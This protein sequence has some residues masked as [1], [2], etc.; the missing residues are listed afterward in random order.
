METMLGADAYFL[1]EETPEMHMHTMKLAVIDP[2]TAATR[3]TF[4][5]FRALAMRQ[6][7]L[8]PSFRRRPLD[9][10]FS[11][12]PPVWLE[13]RDLDANYH[14]QH[15][16]LPAPGG[17]DELN[18]VMSEVGSVS[19][20]RDHP[21]WRFYFIE[22]LENGHIAYLLKIHHAVA[23]GSVS[24]A[25]MAQSFQTSPEGATAPPSAEEL[26]KLIRPDSVLA[27]DTFIRFVLSA[28][29]KVLRRSPSLLGRS[30][31]SI[32]IDLMRILQG[33]ERPIQ[34]FAGPPTRFNRPLSADRIFS[35]VTLSLEDLCTIKKAF[36]C[37]VNDVYLALV[38]GAL[39]RYLDGHREL[40][41][42]DLTAVVPVS[43]REKGDPSIFGNAV[44]QWFATTGSSIVDPAERL[45]AVSRSTRVSRSAFEAKDRTL[46][47]DWFDLWPLRRLY[48]FGL[49][50]VI[51]RFI[52]NPA[53]NVIVS[54]VPGPRVPLFS[55]GAR[56]VSIRSIGP[57][58]RQQGVNFTAW[59][60]LDDFNIT[61]QA[62][63]KE[64]SDLGRMA[65]A[66]APELKDLLEA[67]R[68]EGK[69][70]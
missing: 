62:C 28:S 19:L 15:I 52:K 69:A 49:P 44:S 43:I 13:D 3:I 8:F 55:D 5:D 60:Y 30:V 33:K 16:V 24:A 32:A 23:D 58:T 34:P 12:G 6:L 54:N 59:S 50:A 42:R 18:D 51:S 46:S 17:A 2:S 25:L 48:I 47:K 45:R 53:Y 35:H 26:E 7:P 29:K 63:R 11:L 61:I 27:P 37:T 14:I 70:V 68:R 31:R 64:A 67:A 10:P 66:F 20:R 65:D 1:C 9:A 36:G 21:L 56:V 4:E 57:L 40:P 39:R 38:G 22:G 41:N